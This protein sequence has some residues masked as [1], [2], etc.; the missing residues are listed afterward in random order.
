[1]AEQIQRFRTAIAS[2]TEVPRQGARNG[3][4]YAEPGKPGVPVLA[5]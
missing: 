1:M 3:Y 2:E 4:W 5:D